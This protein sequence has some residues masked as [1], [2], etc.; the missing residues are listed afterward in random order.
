MRV[1]YEQTVRQSDTRPDLRRILGRLAGEP[2]QVHSAAQ[3]G[4]T[5]VHCLAQCEYFMGDTL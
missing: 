4:L 1:H 2:I 3:K 5:L